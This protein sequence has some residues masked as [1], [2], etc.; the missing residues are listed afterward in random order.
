MVTDKELTAREEISWRISRTSYEFVPKGIK[1]KKSELD[2]TELAIEKK[3]LP[4]DPYKVI[5]GDADIETV[6]NNFQNKE[7][8]VNAKTQLIFRLNTYNFPGWTTY[9]NSQ[10]T[11]INDR[12][13]YKLI[14]LNIP[15]GQHELKFVFKNTPVRNLANFLTLTAV[16]VLVMLNIF[17]HLNLRKN[18]S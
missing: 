6:K 2:T 8:S 9:L 5:L 4:Q 12:N 15:Q 14:T 7:F 1:T 13:D 10:K 17:Q 11:S 18:R 3:D 16:G